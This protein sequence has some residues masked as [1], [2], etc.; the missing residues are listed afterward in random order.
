M[1]APAAYAALQRLESLEELDEVAGRAGN[2]V[3]DALPPGPV[4]DGLS[5][6]WLG[7]ALHPVTAYLPLGTWMSAAILDVVGG[8]DAEPAA[9]LL[10]GVGLAAMVPAAATG[11]SDWADS[12]VGD[13][14]QRRVGVVHAAANTV[15]G[16][17][18]AWSLAE[19]RAGRRGRGRLLALAG[20]GVTGFSG[21]LGGHLAFGL[22]SGVDQTTFTEP[23]DEWTP[24]ETDGPVED[25]KPVAGRAGSV[26][27]VLS[28]VDGQVRA[29]AARCCH[30]GGP[31]PEGEVR[32]GCI[33]CPWHGA[34]FAMADGSVVRGPATYPQL[35]YDVREGEAGLEVRAQR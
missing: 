23:L 4:K 27:L 1:T 17:L 25:G 32:D 28:R 8:R 29:L 9:D 13:E 16:G 26:E 3:R 33:T 24:V 35:A 22:G 34:T 15:A 11:A 31:L 7:H 21:W 30:R 14:K 10:I 12:E 19:R 18:M 2:L 5:G 6:V 20:A